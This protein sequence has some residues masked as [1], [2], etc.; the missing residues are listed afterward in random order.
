LISISRTTRDEC[1]WAIGDC[2][3]VQMDDGSLS[4]ARAAA[5]HQMAS[6]VFRN[7]R[8]VLAGE[9]TQ[10]YVYKEMGSLINLSQYKTLV[11]EG[12]IA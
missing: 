9:P 5:A 3:Y 11:V 8:H 2:A 7:I 4:P 10:P 12:R 1:V 6:V